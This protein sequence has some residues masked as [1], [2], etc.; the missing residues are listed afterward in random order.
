MWFIALINA[1][2]NDNTAKADDLW[3]IV[4]YFYEIMNLKI[5]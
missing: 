5:L 4:E 2:E 3:T 1:I